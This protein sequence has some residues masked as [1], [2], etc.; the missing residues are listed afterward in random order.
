MARKVSWVITASACMMVL[1]TTCFAPASFGQSAGPLQ[2]GI[3]QYQ[4]DNYEEAVELLKKAR[5]EAPQST[6][7]AFWLGMAY[8][9]Q[10][11]FPE[12][13]P[14]LTDAVTLSPPI[15]EA[16]VELIDV[17]YRTDNTQEA[18]KWIAVAERDKIYPAKTAFLKGMIL[19][20]EGKFPEAIAS[21]EESKRLDASYAQSADFQIGLAYML[22]RKYAQA[23][24]RFRAAVTQDPVSDLASFARRYQDLVEDRSWVERPVRLTLSMMG[25]Y[26]T[27]MLQEPYSVPGISDA[28]EQQSL[29]M[30]N[31]ARVDFVPV[32]SGNWLFNAGYAV[33]STLHEKNVHT[34][35]VL[36]NNFSVAP[37][38]NFGRF[39]LNLSANYTHVLKRNPSYERYSDNS[40]VGPLLRIMLT[41][42]QDHIL[43][44][45]GGYAQKNYFSAHIDPNEDQT[46]TGIDSYASWVWLFKNGAIFNLK[47]GFTTE[48]AQGNNWTNMGHRFTVNS[49]IP[50]PWRLKLQVG[51]EFFLQDYANENAIPA[52][53]RETRRD[54]TYT[55]I[56]GL[57]WDLNKNL[58][59]LLQYTGI[60]AKSNIFIYDFDRSIYS[61]G[62]EL[63]F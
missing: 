42:Q 58:S 24:E 25:Q 44:I 8:K 63:R 33:S 18:K 60:R 9:Q 62:A 15:R 40:S 2:E 53:N 29:A 52:F 59:L 57:T 37:G 39:A 55:G 32:L 43:E 27:N 49:I 1:L 4:A 14:H 56:A 6:E 10:N 46:A 22:D 48:N 11:A 20:K 5:E 54:R 3:R 12:A 7:A 30:L 34:H 36:V 23:G 51:G 28:G 26:D 13:V 31:T 38:Y 41:E 16:I 61:A 50:L 17:L 47:Y 45:Y 19:V 21:F 35:D